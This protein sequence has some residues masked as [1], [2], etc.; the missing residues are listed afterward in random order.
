[1]DELEIIRENQK[2]VTRYVFVKRIKK[3]NNQLKRK[4]AKLNYW[5]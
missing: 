1:M 2:T 5:S 3:I 4:G